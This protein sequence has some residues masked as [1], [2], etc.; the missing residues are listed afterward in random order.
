MRKSLRIPVLAALVF[1]LGCEGILDTVPSNSINSENFFNS[2]EDAVA[3]LNGA[4]QP[5]QWPNLYNL[6][7][8]ALDMVAGNAEVGAGGGDDGLETKQLA[9][10]LIQPDNPG[11]EDMWRGI[12]PGIAN[13]NFVINRVSGMNNLDAQLKSR[14]IAEARFLRAL[15]YFNGVRLF[16]GLPV[17]LSSSDDQM[18]KR[19]SV[20][21]TYEQIIAD[22]LAAEKD[23]PLSYDGSQF[24]EV[25]RATKGAA[26]G[27]LA[28]VYLTTG[29]YE[30]AEA[31]ARQVTTFN[32]DLHTVF[33]RNFDPFF[34][35]GIES[36]F[37]VQ[38]S[39][40]SA[41]NQFEKK[42]QGSWVTEFTNPRGSGLS[43]WGGFGWGHVTQEFVNSWE[44]GDRRLNHTV[45]QSGDSYGAY[46]YNPGFSSTGY[47]IKKWVRGSSSVTG[48]D[49]NLNFP[50][51]RFADV[52]LMLAEAL[53]EQGKTVEAEP[54]INQVRSR[55]GLPALSGLTQVQMRER[56]LQERR[57]EFAFEGQWWFD[58]MRAG[59]DYAESYFHGL[60]KDNFDKTKHILFPI[61]RTDM[62]LNR[63]MVQNPNY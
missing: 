31:A 9:S 13:S 35:N 16:G 25:G 46:S 61:P 19:E 15:Y 38:Y 18:V 10:F 62:D 55:A 41:F 59:P 53:N 30:L 40:G 49:S 27:L 63:N 24:N 51:L 60:G 23:L 17:I 1:T 11:V 42:H 7:I 58:L 28:K 56:I 44:P 12:W 32:Y 34:N 21:K 43:P 2:P 20:A 8:W 54:H 29:E 6:R 14:I 57:V 45:W 3:A 47:N 5:L 52:L 22:L 39:S 33:T 26:L 36:V 4:Y 50:V 37:E 48:M